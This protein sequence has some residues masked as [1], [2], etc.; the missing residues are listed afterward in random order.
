MTRSAL[1][2]RSGASLGSGAAL[3]A[4]S[5]SPTGRR[6]PPLVSI[7]APPTRSQRSGAMPHCRAAAPTSAARALAAA[8]RSGL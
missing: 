3:A 8:C 4:A 2:G 6:R 1:P 7:T 5:R